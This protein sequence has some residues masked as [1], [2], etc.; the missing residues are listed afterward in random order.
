MVSIFIRLACQRWVSS[1]F[2]LPEGKSVQ[3]LHCMLDGY[4]LSFQEW[5]GFWDYFCPSCLWQ[6]PTKKFLSHG[7]HL[8]EREKD[9]TSQVYQVVSCLPLLWPFLWAAQGHDEHRGL[10]L[11]DVDAWEEPAML[12]VL[13]RHLNYCCQTSSQENRSEYL[14]V[15]M[16]FS[17]ASISNALAYRCV[18]YGDRVVVFH[19]PQQTFRHRSHLADRPFLAWT[20]VE[21][22]GWSDVYAPFTT[23]LPGRTTEEGWTGIVLATFILCFFFSRPVNSSASFLRF[24]PWLDDILTEE[25]RHDQE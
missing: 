9:K 5:G 22:P 25:R 3:L 14:A 7:I 11:Y 4:T 13:R 10:Q 1:Q 15:F 16:A 6:F 12:V 20:S 24:G 18:S 21:T 23:P 2:L 8:M 19:K 17:M